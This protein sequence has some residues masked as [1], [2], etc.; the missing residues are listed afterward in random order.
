MFGIVIGDQADP[1]VTGGTAEV[2]APIVRANRTRGHDAR[3]VTLTG[4]AWCGDDVDGWTE[5]TDDGD[6][7]DAPLH[8]ACRRYFVEDS[9]V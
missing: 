1:Y 4:C 2:L 5:I 8:D 3:L 9:R 7:V 6:W